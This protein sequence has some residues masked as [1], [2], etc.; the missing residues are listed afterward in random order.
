M[1]PPP[2]VHRLPA[3]REARQR[4]LGT[5][6][7]HHHPET[8]PVGR[9]PWYH[10]AGL[11]LP[12]VPSVLCMLA[13][14]HRRCPLR[15]ARRLGD[16]AH[17][18]VAVPTRSESSF[19]NIHNTLFESIFSKIGCMAPHAMQGLAARR[20]GAWGLTHHNT[21]CMNIGNSIGPCVNDIVVFQTMWTWT[22]R[23]GLRVMDVS[24]NGRVVLPH[25]RGS[26]RDTSR[27]VPI[28]TQRLGR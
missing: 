9:I 20:R 13:L 18:S 10:G 15:E 16:A 23:D 7:N 11:H 27:R 2:L 26:R 12:A 6:I 5:T 25:S 3:G 14:R 19:S 28:G 24:A 22:D 17:A 4:R 1:G 8:I 21:P